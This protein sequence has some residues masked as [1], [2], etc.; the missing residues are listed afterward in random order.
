M[1]FASTSRRVRPRMVR[2]VRPID[3]SIVNVVKTLGTTQLATVLITATFPCTI[4]GLRWEVNATAPTAGS[5]T[6]RWAIVRVKD[7]VVVSV[8]AFSDAS[9]LYDPE[10][11]VITWGLLKAADLDAGT[12]PAIAL[13]K[14]DTK[15]MRKLAGGDTIQ[16]ICVSTVAGTPFNAIVQF[17]CKS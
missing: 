13:S 7:G 6:V 14:G 11:E 15:S 12:G 17:F 9:S 3:K 10:Q 1:S 2:S 8:M 16:M 5:A 4:T